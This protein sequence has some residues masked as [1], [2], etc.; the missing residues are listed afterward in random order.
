MKSGSCF[1][2]LLTHNIVNFFGFLLDFCSSCDGLEH[3]VCNM[4]ITPHVVFHC[5]NDSIGI[6]FDLILSLEMKGIVIT[7]K[8]STVKLGASQLTSVPW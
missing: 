5:L 7:E 3:V 2:Y 6:L 8:Q 4:I 1:N